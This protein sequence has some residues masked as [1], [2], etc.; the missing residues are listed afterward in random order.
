MAK[1]YAAALSIALHAA[2]LAAAV[3]SCTL[4][5]A[6][7]MPK[8]AEQEAGSVDFV[9]LPPPSAR[10]WLD[11]EDRYVGVG[12]M[13]N[14]GSDEVTAVSPGGPAELAGLRVGD[15]VTNGDRIPQ[16]S[17]PGHMVRLEVLREGRAIVMTME[18]AWICHTR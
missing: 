4:P 5:I 8:P 1:R 12:Y 7:S 6:P 9:F 3:R 14:W 10:G 16:W 17:E 15:I 2:L 18:S 11:C 13:A